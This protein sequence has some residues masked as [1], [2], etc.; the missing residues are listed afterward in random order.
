MFNINSPLEQ[1]WKIFNKYSIDICFQCVLLLTNIV[2][3]TF[4]LKKKPSIVFFVFSGPSNLLKRLCPFSFRSYNPNQIKCFDVRIQHYDRCLYLLKKEK[5][6][7]LDVSDMFSR[8]VDFITFPTRTKKKEITELRR[9]FDFFTTLSNTSD[10]CLIC[11]R[12]RWKITGKS[13]FEP[14]PSSLYTYTTVAFK[15]FYRISMFE[16]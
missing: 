7:C 2:I 9:S 8:N 14:T 13:N 12:R 1:Y 15:Y 11:P 4:N 10:S 16:K 5:N 3:K 6:G